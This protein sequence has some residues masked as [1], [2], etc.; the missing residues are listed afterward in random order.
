MFEW[1]EVV[2][3]RS[4]VYFSRFQLSFIQSVVC[5]HLLL[6]TLCLCCFCQWWR[7]SCVPSRHVAV[8]T[9]V[10]G[11]MKEQVPSLFYPPPQHS[12]LLSHCLS[13]LLHWITLLHPLQ[14]LSSPCR[15]SLRRKAWRMWSIFLHPFINWLSLASCC[16]CRPHSC[17][18]K[19]DENI[20]N[21]I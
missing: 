18:W 6:L 21:D 16:V 2:C 9:G 7:L 5:S 17:Q 10:K 1:C 15:L 11:R 3:I 14:H 4:A 19:W 20:E 8:V 13:V 12:L